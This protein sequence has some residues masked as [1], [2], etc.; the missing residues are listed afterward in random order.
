M[1]TN[2]KNL[3]FVGLSFC[4]FATGQTPK[5]NSNV[6]LHG[7][8]ALRSLTVVIFDDA[9]TS[10]AVLV[11][12]AEEARHAFRTTGV[13]TAWMIC[14]VFQGPNQHCDLP[15]AGTY[16][17]V[18][19]LPKASK[20]A[21]PTRET[22]GYAMRCPAAERCATSYVFYD[23][24]LEFAQ[25]AGQPPA[26]ALAY[27]M[28]HEVGHLI[29]MDHSQRGIMKAR[30]DRRDL[31]DAAAGQLRFQAHEATSLR[32]A[33]ADWTGSIQATTFADAR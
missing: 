18:K 3:L 28:A 26:V 20:G 15:P 16:L 30:F 33:I 23:T 19:I 17:E 25:R 7:E 29:G 11:S 12:A 21:F 5:Q 8:G 32:A 9:T 22:T 13:E 14:P 24:V 1:N 2:W 31:Q 10:R 27:V 6:L 4:T